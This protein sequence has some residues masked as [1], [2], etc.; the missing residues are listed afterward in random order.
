MLNTVHTMVT[1]VAATVCSTGFAQQRAACAPEMETAFDAGQ[2][3]MTPQEQ[4]SLLKAAGSFAPELTQHPRIAGTRGVISSGNISG[5]Y[6]AVYFG[7]IPV[8]PSQA[9]Y[10][11]MTIWGDIQR[12]WTFDHLTRHA[13]L[14][15][16]SHPT[17]LWLTEPVTEAQALDALRQLRGRVGN[18][19]PSDDVSWL[20]L[21]TPQELRNV[22]RF[23]YH[24]WGRG[25]LVTPDEVRAWYYEHYIVTAISQAPGLSEHDY[26]AAVNF[27]V[28]DEGL[29]FVRV[30]R[31]DCDGTHAGYASCVR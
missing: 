23:T 17:W 4:E 29:K 6:G 22:R 10:L 18:G 7:P 1:L 2:R 16:D 21:I 15:V 3:I 27:A 19:P 14:H 12:G 11:S 28:T 8:S 20:E 5:Y 24:Y 30:Y 9:Q 26:F 31:L 25:D 13:C